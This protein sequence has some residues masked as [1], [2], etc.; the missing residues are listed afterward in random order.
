MI[1]LGLISVFNSCADNSQKGKKK[2][3]GKTDL[4]EVRVTQAM[5]TA[6]ADSIKY[7][8]LIGSMAEA[9]ISAEANNP[10]LIVG[11]DISKGDNLM[12]KK[13]A[14]IVYSHHGVEQRLF[15]AFPDDAKYQSLDAD[16][17]N[18]FATSYISVKW[19]IE[20][21]YN[22]FAGLGKSKFLKWELL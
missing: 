2:N 20:N 6:L 16:N 3:E 4:I 21:W 11:K 15:L 22:H 5:G 14:T 9:K 13:I 10:F 8:P 17:F 7:L 1:S 12:V 18:D 19:Q